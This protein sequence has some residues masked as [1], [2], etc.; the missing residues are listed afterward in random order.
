MSDGSSAARDNVR[1]RA[2]W[3]R[4]MAA[5]ALVLLLAIA[6]AVPRL[7]RAQA[8]DDAARADSAAGVGVTVTQAKRSTASGELALTGTV[9]AL[10]ETALYARSSGYVGHW[11]ADLGAH[12]RAGQLLATIETPELDHE[13]DQSRADLARSQSTLSLAERNLQRWKRLE[14]DSAVS[15]QE[16]DERQG[17]FDEAKASADAA[18]ANVRRLVSLKSFAQITAPFAGVITSRNLD[19]GTL[20]APGTANGARGLY[21]LAQTDTLRIM[22]SVPQS[23]VAAI[24][25]GLAA[26]IVIP[27]LGGRTVRGR[28]MRTANALDATSR[29]LLVEVQAPNRDGALLPGMYAEVHFHLA[30][31]AAPLVVPAATLVI[32]SEGPTV[33]LVK[34]DSTIQFTKVTLGRDHGS[35]VE[36]LGGIPD[37][38]LLVVNP[39][40][41][42]VDGIRVRIVG[43]PPAGDQIASTWT[44]ESA[45]RPSRRRKDRSREQ[46]ATCYLVSPP[47]YSVHAAGWN[48][49]LQDGRLPFVP[50]LRL[51]K[52]HVVAAGI[53]PA[54][55]WVHSGSHTASA[56]MYPQR[57]GGTMRRARRQG[58]TLIELL[59]V[60]VIIGILAA[61][62]IPKFANTKE[63]AYLASMKSDLR[64]LATAQES[65]FADNQ[66]Y[67]TSTIAVN[68]SPSAGVTVTIPD[69]AGTKW[70]AQATHPATTKVCKI[71]FG[72][73]T[74][75]S[76]MSEGVS[77][78]Q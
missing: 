25:P 54:F 52:T 23:S 71:G 75:Y 70:E 20:V 4:L 61:I 26:D 36:V 29:T 12:V 21:T 8:L 13:L 41:D 58:F 67:T 50:A 57:G 7:R 78:C 48:G 38:A 49:A 17:A 69:A 30:Q 19:V 73:D 65:Y 63:K 32:R 60:V 74:T 53:A 55:S 44:G 51:A 18:Q 43:S 3:P 64:N 31:G 76:G 14:R 28:V 27:D 40:D 66:T 15:T 22:V 24:T 9:Q 72:A 35:E 47:D 37:G 33:A 39:S 11:T 6:G 59:I 2:A 68:F 56:H 1:P 46:M 42:V 62:A 16:L 10:H 34:A 45:G 5:V 77:N